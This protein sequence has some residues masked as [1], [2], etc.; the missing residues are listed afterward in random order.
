MES[1]NVVDP[2]YDM[3]HKSDLDSNQQVPSAKG[4]GLLLSSLMRKPIMVT[5][6]LKGVDTQVYLLSD[7]ST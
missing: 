1:E 3:A 5:Y 2:K 6:T 7:S 4:E